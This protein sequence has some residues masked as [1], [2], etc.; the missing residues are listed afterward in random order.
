MWILPR[1]TPYFTVGALSP[2]LPWSADISNDVGA[3]HYSLAGFDQHLAVH[4]KL[5]FSRASQS[6][7]GKSLSLTQSFAKLGKRSRRQTKAKAAEFEHDIFAFV[8]L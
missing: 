8:S 1:H 2:Q 6:Q 7:V 5:Y 3:S 4:G